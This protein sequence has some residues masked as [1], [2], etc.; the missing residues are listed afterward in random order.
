MLSTLIE[1]IHYQLHTRIYLKGKLCHNA[2][3]KADE[4]NVFL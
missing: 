2:L 1:R 4:V 3:S